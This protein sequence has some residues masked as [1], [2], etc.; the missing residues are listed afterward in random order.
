MLL[1]ELNVSG[2]VKITLLLDNKSTIDLENHP[3]SHGRNKQIRRRH[4]LRN[5]I[6]KERLK[7]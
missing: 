2:I 5:Q 3:M 7:I 6:D 1:E 4:F